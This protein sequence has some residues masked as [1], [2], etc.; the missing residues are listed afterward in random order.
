MKLRDDGDLRLEL[1]AMVHA[2]DQ[3]GGKSRFDLVDDILDAV[4]RAIATPSPETGTAAGPTER[5]CTVT[6][7]LC[8]TDTTLPGGCSCASCAAHRAGPA[9]EPVKPPADLDPQERCMDLHPRG[10]GYGYCV[11][12]SGHAG[13]HRN[14]GHDWWDARTPVAGTAPTHRCVALRG[15]PGER[16]R[17]AC[18]IEQ[19]GNVRCAPG[20]CAMAP[21]PA[22]EPG[23]PA[24]TPVYCDQFEEDIPNFGTNR[25]THRC[26]KAH[27]S[28]RATPEKG[29]R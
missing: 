12:P 8:G 20:R 5:R 21:A 25:D 27:R 2:R 19:E 16:E 23:K 24:T 13:Q 9:L 15:E 4:D 10:G 29:G 11:L 6:G 22:A 3:H 7:H 14:Y 17:D 18:D 26:A 1:I 28:R